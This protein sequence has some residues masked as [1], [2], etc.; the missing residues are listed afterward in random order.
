M[1]GTGL[2]YHGTSSLFRYFAIFNQT[3]SNF[4]WNTLYYAHTNRFCVVQEN[5]KP[6]VLNVQTDLARLSIKTESLHFP[7]QHKTG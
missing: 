7:L 4:L 5:V 1:S 3:P 2:I 6:E